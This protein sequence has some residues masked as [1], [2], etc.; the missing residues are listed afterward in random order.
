MNQKKHPL[1]YIKLFNEIKKEFLSSPQ[2][3]LSYIFYEYKKKGNGFLMIEIILNKQ[4]NIRTEY[5]IK[6]DSS[7]T[8]YNLNNY[9]PDNTI[10]FKIKI[11]DNNILLA[12]YTD[13]IQCENKCLL[14]LKSP[15]KGF[16][17]ILDIIDE[18]FNKYYV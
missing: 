16:K 18:F 12:E 6:G 5:Q 2:K 17:N 4:I 3:Y 9:I 1:G 7:I 15:I 13:S 14:A 11:I 8:E 10:L